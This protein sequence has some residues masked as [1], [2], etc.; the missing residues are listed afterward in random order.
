MVSDSAGTYHF[1]APE[2]CVGEP[3]SGYGADIWALGVILYV[4]AFGTV[5][6]MSGEVRT[7]TTS[8]AD[9]DNQELFDIIAECKSCPCCFRLCQVQVSRE[10]VEQGG[11]MQ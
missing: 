2:S 3:Y 11:R 6:F 1:F 8:T 9:N 4:F 10:S 5:P 7:V